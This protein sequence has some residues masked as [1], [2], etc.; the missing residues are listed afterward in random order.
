[1]TTYYTI[2]PT[3]A[4]YVRT[5]DRIRIEGTSVTVRHIYGST[6]TAQPYGMRP[7]LPN[8]RLYTI[9]PDRCPPFTVQGSHRLDVLI[10]GGRKEP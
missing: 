8:E 9:V 5:G 2:R 10:G 7:N 4:Q 6:A 3:P 1:M